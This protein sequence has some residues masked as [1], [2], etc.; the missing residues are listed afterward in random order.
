MEQL[1]AVAE[2]IDSDKSSKKIEIEIEKEVNVSNISLYARRN[3]FLYY[4]DQLVDRNARYDVLRDVLRKIII[5]YF[6]AA[7]EILTPFLSSLEIQKDHLERNVYRPEPH[8]THMQMDKQ[9]SQIFPCNVRNL[10]TVYIS[11]EEIKLLAEMSDENFLLDFLS[12]FDISYRA[13]PGYFNHKNNMVKAFQQYFK[14]VDDHLANAK[15]LIPGLTWEHLI[16]NLDIIEKLMVQ[17]DQKSQKREAI[18]L[19]RMYALYPQLQN[20]LMPIILEKCNTQPICDRARRVYKPNYQMAQGE[21]EVP[22]IK[23]NT[24]LIQPAVIAQKLDKEGLLPS[25]IQSV[26]LSKHVPVSVN[27]QETEY[28]KKTHETFNEINEEGKE[29]SIIIEGKVKSEYEVTEKIAVKPSQEQQKSF[30]NT[31]KI[32]LANEKILY[33]CRDLDKSTKLTVEEKVEKILLIAKNVNDYAAAFKLMATYINKHKNPIFD[34]IFSNNNTNTWKKIMNHIRKLALKT[35]M[36]EV[37]N[38]N[39]ID[40]KIKLLQEAC[41][42]PLFNQHRNNHWFTGGFGDTA[43]VSVIKQEIANLEGQN[44]KL[45]ISI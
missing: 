34:T 17:D 11:K 19:M 36:D 25:H 21:L 38:I 1:D 7:K 28:E 37:I 6:D 24:E 31:I 39:D 30:E 20:Q 3:V 13:K 10:Y 44:S 12:R 35:L 18:E 22:P 23:G 2:R 16:S 15:R 32:F 41:Q 14:K 33:A 8:T 42:M 26:L 29:I 4:L 45:R 5:D 43:A 40:K 27:M 9:L